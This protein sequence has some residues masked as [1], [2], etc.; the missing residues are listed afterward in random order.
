MGAA[1]MKRTNRITLCALMASL[2]VVLM[3]GAY[4]PY[5]TYTIPAFAGLCVMVVMLEIGS[6]WAL[7]TY[8]TSAALTILFCEPEA[9]L[10]YVFL[11]G[12]YPI[13]KAFIERINNQII[14]WPI[15]LIIF[16]VIV[17]MVYN[18]IAGLFGVTI[19]FNND[20]GKYAIYG[21]L[22]LANAVFI[23]YDI[24]VS[25]MAAFYFVTIQPKLR[26]ILK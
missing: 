22:G 8:I 6:S 24:T 14:E 18:F 17:I 15:K 9:M 7:S 25:K 11:F 2:A 10:L 3:L 21:L 12:Y 26:K 13:L 16:N 20:V 5:L 19:T 1:N 23:V 4:F